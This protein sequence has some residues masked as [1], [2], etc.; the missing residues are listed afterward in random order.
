MQIVLSKIKPSEKEDKRV[1]NIV[2]EFLDKLNNKLVRAYA[3]VGGSFGKDTW[4]VGDHDIDI[5]VLFEDD[6]DCSNILE[7]ALKR[8]FPKIERI[9]GSRDY[10]QVL[11]KNLNFEIVPVFRI[12]KAEQARNV[13]DVS[14]LHIKWV[15]ERGE[16]KIRDEIRLAKQFCK[17]QKVYGA[18]TFIKGFSGYV[19]ELLVIYYGSFQN[20]IKGAS[21]WKVGHVINPGNR[22]FDLNP[23]KLSPLIVIDPVQ[24]NRNAAA[25]LSL[26]CFEKF[27]RSCILYLKKPEIEFFEIKKIKL[28][29]LKDKDLVFIAEALKGKKDVIGTKLLK[30]YDF[31]FSELNNEG[32]GVVNSGWEWN[33]KAYFWFNVKKK[34][35][36]P[37]KERAGPPLDKKENAEE[38]RKK[39]L[40]RTIVE[41]DERL[42]VILPR[43][44]V[45]LKDF[46]KNL[47]KK[48]EIKENVMK[49]KLN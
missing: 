1:D 27:I 6:I 37:F 8:S 36:S 20:L 7:L 30:V 40:G 4:L 3:V 49:I 9:H 46:V 34:E 38:F 10:F 17:A 39:H 14:P 25:A 48:Q 16:D 47:L 21:K 31:I 28:E 2:K 19:M 29:E 13:T 33:D 45:K 15:R 11:Y 42:Y 41:K 12:I 18:E 22:D 44:F 32:Y 26:D 43:Q 35:L 23:D 5:F 24:P